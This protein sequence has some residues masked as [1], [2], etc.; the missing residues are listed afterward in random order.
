MGSSGSKNY[1][2]SLCHN[3]HN[4]ALS[5]NYCNS[6]CFV[7]AWAGPPTTKPMVSVSVLCNSKVEGT[8]ARG[9]CVVGFRIKIRS[10]MYIY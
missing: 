6:L 1:D 7:K 3:I 4:F 8:D 5:H 10:Y 9:E 2:I